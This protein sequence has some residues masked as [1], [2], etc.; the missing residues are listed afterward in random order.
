MAFEY[1]IFLAILKYHFKSFMALYIQKPVS[2]SEKLFCIF[3]ITPIKLKEKQ[4]KVMENLR[5]LKLRRCTNSEYI[6][7]KI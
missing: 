3:L 5:F 1:N 4:K 6:V 2:F 7:Y